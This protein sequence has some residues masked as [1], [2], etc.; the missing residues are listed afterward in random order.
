MIAAMLIAAAT[1][2]TAIDAERAFAADAQKLGQWTAFRKWAAPGAVMFAPDVVYAQEWLRGKTDP[3]KSIRWQPAASYQSCDGTVAINVGPWQRPDGSF[4]YF[5]TVWLYETQLI[6]GARWMWVYDAGEALETPMQAA[7]EPV[8]R[9][10]SCDAIPKQTPGIRR[11]PVP[12]LPSPD[13]PAPREAELQSSDNS[14]IYDYSAG[15]N[16]ARTLIAWLWNGRGYEPVLHQ[17][18][19]APPQ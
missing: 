19:A 13:S 11:H 5:T 2:M 18:V 16:G 1:P 4:G 3:P 15:V 10:A 7:A 8:V 17:Q 6:A 9:R 12:S 14:L